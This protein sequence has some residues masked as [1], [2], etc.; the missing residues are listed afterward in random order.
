[1][2]PW[3]Y[4]SL[5]QSALFAQVYLSQYYRKIPKT[6][7]TRKMAVIILKLKRGFHTEVSK[8][9]RGNGKQC[10]AWSD[11]SSRSSLI[12]VHTVCSDLSVQKFRN[13]TVSTFTVC[14]YFIS[15]WATV[16]TSS[17]R[18]C[19]HPYAMFSCPRLEATGYNASGRPQHRVVIVLTLAQTVI[20]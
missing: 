19:G 15:P 18:C 7:D 20:K 14:N 2:R 5:W 11:C 6:S 3:S 8:T 17:A 1:M 4:G 9:C 12:W 10:R 13:I 16:K